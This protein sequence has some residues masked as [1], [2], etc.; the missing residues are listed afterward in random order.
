MEQSDTQN[1]HA[2]EPESPSS[3]EVPQ[4]AMLLTQQEW[5]DLS[6]MVRFYQTETTW[7]SEPGRHWDDVV[8]RRQ[9]AARIIK[10]VES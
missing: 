7:A 1:G 9:L 6:L 5:E 10:A 8:R 4:T 3:D 2:S